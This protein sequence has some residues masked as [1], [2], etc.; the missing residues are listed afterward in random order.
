[1]NSKRVELIKKVINKLISIIFIML[2][3]AVISLMIQKF[4]LKREVPD[5][6][7]YKI[8]Q[9]MSGSMSGEFET[10]DT[11]LIKK[12]DDESNLKIGDVVTYRIKTNTLV[13][14]R[15]INITRTGESLSYTT[16]GDANNT[17]DMEKVTF[18]AIE[19]IYVKKLRLI[20]NL[21][22]FMQKTYGM[23]IIFILPIVMII[24]V[25]N[26]EKVKEEKRNKRREKRL[27]Y[28]LQ[29][30]KEYLKNKKKEEK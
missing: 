3:V 21:I 13:T 27:N 30:S 24:C 4:V 23:V 20:S 6:F 17:E 25:V 15:I 28:E 26:S 1:M 16:K 12:I 14:H 19:G 8:L 29:K 7:G 18:S 9:V 22:K 10:G 2:F 5:L 11:I